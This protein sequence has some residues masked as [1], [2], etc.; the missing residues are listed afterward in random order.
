MCSKL[1]L[2]YGLLQNQMLIGSP[3]CI[4]NS[5]IESDTSL[6]K[7]SQQWRNVYVGAIVVMVFKVC[8]SHVEMV[9][10]RLRHWHSPKGPFA[11]YSG[12]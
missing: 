1:N 2:L 3:Q 10:S 8:A 5:L 7:D 12:I 11:V 9:V 6:N 4:Q